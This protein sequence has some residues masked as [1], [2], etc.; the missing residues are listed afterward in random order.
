ML[1]RDRHQEAAIYNGNM[2]THV[3][4]VDASY[5]Y[6][7]ITRSF[8]I[9]T[10][11]AS[12]SSYYVQ[13]LMQNSNFQHV[14][15]NLHASANPEIHMPMNNM[16]NYV[17]QY[18]TPNVI[19]FNSMQN[20]VSF[21]YPSANNL[22]FFASPSHVPMDN[23]ADYGTTSYLANYS[24]P[25][26][27]T[28]Y[29]TNFSAPYVTS[30]IHNSTA[31][32]HSTYG[33]ISENSIEDDVPSSNTVACGTSPKQLQ[34]F[35]NT[36]VSLPKNNERSKRQSSKKWAEDLEKEVLAAIAMQANHRK[37]VDSISTVNSAKAGLDNTRADSNQQK[38]I[39]TTDLVQGELK[40]GKSKSG[41]QAEFVSPIDTSFVEQEHGECETMVLDFSR[42][43]GAF[44]LPYEFRAKE[45]DVHPLEENIA[46]PSSVEKRAWS[47]R[48]TRSR[49][50]G[51]QEVGR[52]R[53]GA[54]YCSGHA[55]T[56]LSH[57]E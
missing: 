40:L 14:N 36:H 26:Y 38:L 52:S 47:G 18:E 19:N 49:K 16:M 21:F 2:N 5:C 13:E 50:E 23:A 25:S 43:K 12:P 9:H 10:A 53:G 8:D 46:E 24:E 6:T 56:L 33:R 42:C 45:I 28:P 11:S 37:K 39:S 22:Q 35:G 20:N 27:V 17:S 31:H 48:S 4:Y 55:T 7:D 34:N 30:D 1:R 41:T 32:L 15:S 3:P 29:V 57:R 51:R 54:R 44:M